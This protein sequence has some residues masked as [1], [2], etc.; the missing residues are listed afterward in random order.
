MLVVSVVELVATFDVRRH[1]SCV[2]L[3]FILDF[4]LL[5]YMWPCQDAIDNCLIVKR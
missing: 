3:H 5:H 1:H 4:K 2:R